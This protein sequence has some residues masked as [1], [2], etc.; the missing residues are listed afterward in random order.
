MATRC[1]VLVQI[2]LVEFPVD[3]ML[4][5]DASPSM[6]RSIQDCSDLVVAGS[7]AAIYMLRH[8]YQASRQVR[9]DA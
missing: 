5:V 1:R 6:L 2:W 9:V 7:F 8:I 4:L 3:G